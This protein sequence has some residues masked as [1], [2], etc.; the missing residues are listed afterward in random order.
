VYQCE[1]YKEYEGGL[2]KWLWRSSR[3]VKEV[4]Q[5]GILGVSTV[6]GVSFVVVVI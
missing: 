1:E 3:L 5:S 6:R 4:K 2:V